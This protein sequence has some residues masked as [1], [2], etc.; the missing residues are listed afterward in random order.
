VYIYPPIVPQ[1]LMLWYVHTGW[2]SAIDPALAGGGAGDCNE[3]CLSIII[4]SSVLGALSLCWYVHSLLAMKFPCFPS[5][6][7]KSANS[8]AAI[9][10]SRRQPR[11][12][13]V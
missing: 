12:L 7:Y 8:D 2:T 1:L 6:K 4:T 3:V 10:A 11:L 9:L 5:T 13:P